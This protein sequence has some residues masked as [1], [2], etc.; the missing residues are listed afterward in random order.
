MM[1]RQAVITTPRELINIAIKLL[2]EVD[3]KQKCMINIVNKTKQSD[4]WRF[5]K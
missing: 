1:Q 2:E 5:E 4:T 3:S